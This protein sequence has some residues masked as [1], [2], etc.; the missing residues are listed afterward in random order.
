M[1]RAVATLPEDYKE[2][3]SV[4]LVRDRKAALAVNILALLIAVALVLLGLALT[5]FRSTFLDTSNGVLPIVAKCVVLAASI[6]LYIALHELTHGIVMKAFGAKKVK[7][8]F[9]VVYAC[10]GSD[11]YYPKWPYITIALAPVAVFLVVFALLAGH[12]P[13]G[14]FWV[15][16]ILQ[17]TNLAGAAGDY[18]V[19]VKFIALPKDILIRDSGAVMTVYSK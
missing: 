5:P 9:K 12:L 19:T 18:Y 2:L 7:Y 6:L 14:W 1:T 16:W 8:G 10:A 15:A 11:D 4:D 17:V 13:E 3:C